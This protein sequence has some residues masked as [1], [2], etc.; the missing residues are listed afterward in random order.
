MK[1]GTTETHVLERKILM[2]CRWKLARRGS[3]ARSQGRP[4]V[5]HG[6]NA[7]E[8][9]VVRCLH[10]LTQQVS[11]EHLCEPGTLPGDGAP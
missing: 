9:L 7:A 11:V 4:E 8:G 10:S 1:A 5:R 6:G 2:A 3:P